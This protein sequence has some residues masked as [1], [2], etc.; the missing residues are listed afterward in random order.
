MAL[1]GVTDQLICPVVDDA[2]AS[3]PA[4]CPGC[5]AD[6][7]ADGEANAAGCVA[8]MAAVTAASSRPPAR[9]RPRMRRGAAVL[10]LVGSRRA[11]M[12]RG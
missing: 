3:P 4:D 8:Q 2:D 9:T 6:A 5:D 7:G 1:A 11:A 12:R 10:W